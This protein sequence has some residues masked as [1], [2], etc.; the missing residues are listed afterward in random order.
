M[1][2]R[3]VAPLYLPQCL[4][5]AMV[6]ELPDASIH[7]KRKVHG[8]NHLQLPGL[9]RQPHVGPFSQFIPQVVEISAFLHFCLSQKCNLFSQKASGL[10][11]PHFRPLITSFHLR[12][13]PPSYPNSNSNP[14]SST[15]SPCR[16]QAPASQPQAKAAPSSQPAPS[17]QASSLPHSQTPFSPSRTANLCAQPATTAS[18]SSPLLQPSPCP[19]APPARRPS[20]AM[21]SVNERT[22]KPCI[23]LSAGCSLG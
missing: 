8:M 17:N 9:F 19:P 14:A 6:G 12:L 5:S 18:A 10:E 3:W 4:S 1:K 15:H 22:G 16:P 23:R 2:T 21:P 13:T 11:I 20:T 7:Y